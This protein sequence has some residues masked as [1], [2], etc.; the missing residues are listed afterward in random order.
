MKIRKILSVVFYAILFFMPSKNPWVYII[1][2]TLSGIGSGLYGMIIWAIVGDVIDY[3]EYL[4]GKREEGIVYATYSLSRKLVQAIVGGICAFALAIIGYKSGSSTQTPE[5][6]EG[7]RN[8][9]ILVP[10]IGYAFGAVCLKFIYNLNNK[11]LNEVNEELKKHSID[12]VVPVNITMAKIAY[13][14]TE[15]LIYGHKFDADFYFIKKEE[16]DYEK[17]AKNQSNLTRFG[18]SLTPID[19]LYDEKKKKNLL[20]KILK[21]NLIEN[22]RKLYLNNN[23]QNQKPSCQLCHPNNFEQLQLHIV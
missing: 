16:I 4:S 17:V 22:M 18:M 20:N 7:I 9:I 13:E 3:Q 2:T 11:T 1:L 8:I 14:K 6:A 12:A 5:V 15:T 21:K 19:V 10:L 23:K